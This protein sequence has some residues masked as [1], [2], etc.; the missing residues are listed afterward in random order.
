MLQACRSRAA[1]PGYAAALEVTGDMKPTS[2]TPVRP[3]GRVKRQ[4]GAHRAQPL[5]RY[6]L[7]RIP[8]TWLLIVLLWSAGAATGSLVSGP[9]QALGPFVA[10]GPD[11]LT[12][13]EWGPALASLLFPGGVASYVL[14]TVVLLLCVGFAETTLGSGR[15]LAAVMA[16]H[17]AAVFLFVGSVAAGDEL[18][19][20]WLS[21]MQHPALAGPFAGSLA[22]VMAASPGISPLWRR[23]LR[24]LGLA[25]TIMLLLY[26][27]HPQNV[28]AFLGVL[29]GLASGWAAAT[30]RSRAAAKATTRRAANGA[31]S[32]ANVVYPPGAVWTGRD[33]RSTLAMTVAVFAAGPV[34]AGLSQAPIGPLAAL[35]NL[36]VNPVPTLGELQSDCAAAV[37][38]GCSQI[39]HSPGLHG[40][41]G[42]AL[43]VVPLL[44]LLACA[45]GLRR[46]SRVALWIATVAHL[47]VGVLSAIY[48]Q[49]FAHFGVSVRNGS[50]RI[51]VDSGI[52]EILPVVLV[53]LLIAAALFFNRRHFPVDTD[54]A[55]GRRA[56]VLVPGIFAAFVALYVLAWFAEGNNRHRAGLLSL[57]TTLPRMFLPYPFSF[58]YSVSVHPR[59]Y[60]SSLIFSYGGAAFWLICLVAVLVIFTK[61]RLWDHRVDDNR[62]LARRL[63]F[64][65]GG[66]LSW[67]ALWPNNSYWFNRAGTVGIAYQLHHGIALTAGGPFG[68]ECDF[69]DAV[70]E[71]TGYCAEQSLTPC[72]YSVADAHWAELRSLGFRGMEVAQETVLPLTGIDFRGREWQSVRTAMNKARRLGITA[73]WGVYSGLPDGLRSQVHDISE[74]WAYSRALPEMGFT[75]GGVE[76]LKDDHVLLCLAVDPEGAVL[77]VTSWLPV[78]RNGEVVSRTLDFMRRREDCFNGV[79]EFLIASAVLHFKDSMAEISLSGSPL[80]PAT[81]LVPR[82]AEVFPSA[83]AGLPG[84]GATVADDGGTAGRVLRWLGD[85]LEPVYGFRSLAAFKQRFQPQH[86]T[87]FILYQDPLALPLIGRALAEAYLPNWSVR[88]TARLIRDITGPQPA[89]RPASYGEIALKK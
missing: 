57:G 72:W 15:A 42:A 50:R 30:A 13:G 71:F 87:L 10:I 48:L 88:H 74:R 34:L 5:P 26:V 18:G 77:G 83:G 3:D 4:A 64:Q 31:A 11:T 36:I 8:L 23:R 61:R 62:S 9:P 82:Q 65:G 60:W 44:L 6:G 32:R 80:V 49:L 45:E 67:M 38:A 21:S 22:A 59:G 54:P 1:E 2:S 53:P 56:L 58:K 86:R 79:M 25:V 81:A 33:V 27:G 85:V 16:G 29:S 35:R 14:A 84:K 39:M 69:A 52:V 28:L 73:H 89:R 76:Q 12:R 24:S 51:P 55:L 68:R 43:S 41:G 37:N 20:S 70:R 75:L 40:P 17:L 46:G 47:A 63:V 7:R 66:S 19:S 78:F